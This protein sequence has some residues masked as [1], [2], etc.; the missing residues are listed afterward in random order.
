MIMKL[1]LHFYVFLNISKNVKIRNFGFS[2]NLKNVFSKTE[3]IVQMK[4]RYMCHVPDSY[5]MLI[6]HC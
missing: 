2:K 6:A 5:C 3:H 1:G 4:L